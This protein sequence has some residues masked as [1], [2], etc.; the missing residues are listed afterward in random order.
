MCKF[1]CYDVLGTYKR[2][3]KG[4][5]DSLAQNN[6]SVSH[7][8]IQNEKYHARF[9]QGAE[10]AEEFDKISHF[11]RQ[12]KEPFP[13]IIGITA[14]KTIFGKGCYGNSSIATALSILLALL[15]VSWYSASGSESAT[16]PAPDWI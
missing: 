6:L 12:T 1:I 9:A 15:S 13:F 16:R 2:W 7:K 4:N 8:R 10:H 5:S 14:S 11:S 3:N